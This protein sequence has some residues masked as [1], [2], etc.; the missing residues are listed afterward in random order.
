MSA[1]SL[2]DAVSPEDQLLEYT[3]ALRRHRAGRFALHF[4]LSLLSEKNSGSFANRNAAS[5]FHAFIKADK[6]KLF[7]LSSNDIVFISANVPWHE[8][9]ALEGK[10]TGF[11]D[12]DENIAGATDQLSQSFDLSDDFDAFAAHCEQIKEDADAQ[13][14]PITPPKPAPSDTNVRSLLERS[15]EADAPKPLQKA[16]VP[17]RLIFDD[18]EVKSLSP[19]D[20]DRLESNFRILDPTNL[21]VDMPVAAVIGDMP[22]QTIFSEKAIDY[23]SLQAAVLPSRD[24]QSDAN[25]F[26][27]LRCVVEQQLIKKLQLPPTNNALANSFPCNVKTVLSGHFISFDRNHRRNSNVPLIIDIRLHDALVHMQEFLQMRDRVRDAGYRVCLSG[28][29]PHGFA[30]MDHSHRLADFIKVT[31]PPEGT[32]LDGKWL[33]HF[34]DSA[35][36]AGLNRLIFSHCDTAEDLENGRQLGFSLFQGDFINMMIA[37]AAP[38][39][40]AAAKG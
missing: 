30:V 24:M 11:F 32:L 39:A 26:E 25:L 40:A 36:K 31:A 15:V 19:A 27:R 22:P 21:L 4:K 1:S 38:R 20:L 16:A 29:S 5:F 28:M 37:E 34:H 10:V 14:I 17:R 7:R 9:H 12:D 2:N 23:E 13:A 6:G 3:H 18:E 8:L 35:R 33:D